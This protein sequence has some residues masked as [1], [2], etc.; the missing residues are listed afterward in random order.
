M[1]ILSSYNLQVTKKNSV[2]RLSYACSYNYNMRR[3][4][5]KLIMVIH[6]SENNL[7]DI[8]DDKLQHM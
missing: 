3:K 8:K 4:I 5:R 6:V 2:R 7:K 1:L